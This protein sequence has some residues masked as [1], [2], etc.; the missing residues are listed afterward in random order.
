MYYWLGLFLFSIIS[1]NFLSIYLS[2]IT[3]LLLLYFI[4]SDLHIIGETKF[5]LGSIK[6]SQL[7][8][9]K[10]TGPYKESSFYYQKACEILTKF[11]LND[12]YEYNCFG[13]YFD[14]PKKVK[15]E[16]CRSVIGIIF[17]P[18]DDKM[19]VNKEMV[20]YIQNQDWFSTEIPGA[21]A[22]V[23]RFKIVHYALCLFAI[24]RYYKDLE[25]SLCDKDFI[26]KMRF[27]PE[28]IVGIMELC[29]PSMMEFYVPIGNQDK[30]K[31]WDVQK[32]GN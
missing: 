9:Q 20:E 25:R 29:K 13:M 8:F 4:L 18:S 14:D 26:G 27:D 2:Y 28:K 12:K 3:L 19:T 30:F 24:K 10:V 17:T 16:S 6:R 32:V 11:K 15:E 21:P 23:S 31:F 22:I 1:Y 5:N 7:F